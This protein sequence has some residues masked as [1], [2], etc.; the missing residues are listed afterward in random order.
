VS[1][2][3]TPW[4]VGDVVFVVDQTGQVICA[5][6]ESGQLYWIRDLN[7][8]L[9]KKQRAYWSSPILADNRLIVASSTGVAVAINPKTG[10]VESRLKLGTDALIGPIAAGGMVYIASDGGQLIAIR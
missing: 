2:I 5:S 4:P 3:T 8:G 9:K 7:E 10:V 6:R 1:A